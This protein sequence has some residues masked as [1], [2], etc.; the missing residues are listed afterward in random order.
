MKKVF[1]KRV[2][3]ALYYLYCLLDDFS[4]SLEDYPD[5]QNAF[6]NLERVILSNLDKGVDLQRFSLNDVFVSMLYEENN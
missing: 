1:R 2:S 3:V 6:D 4:W 5:V